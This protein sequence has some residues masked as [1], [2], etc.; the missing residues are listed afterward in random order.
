MRMRIALLTA[1]LLATFASLASAGMFGLQLSNGTADLYDPRTAPGGYISAFDHSELGA[2]AQY[3]H[4]FSPDYALALAAGI[5]FFSE[6][7]EPGS[8][9]PPA[10]PTRQFTVSS[11]HLRVGGDR[12]VN[13][14]EKAAIYFGPGIEYWSG[15]SKFEGFGPTTEESENVSRI[16]LSG[17]MGGIMKITSGFALAGDVGH[18]IGR[19]SA[20]DEGAKAT[21]WAS[22]FDAHGG[23]LFTF[24]GG[25]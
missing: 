6:D 16:S 5:G 10:S 25:E 4:T 12:V 8:G 22:S 17:R 15:K 13:L 20:E 14:S 11:F 24:G 1:L 7:N 2:R 9:A 3:W 18:K 23:V 19:A 21:W